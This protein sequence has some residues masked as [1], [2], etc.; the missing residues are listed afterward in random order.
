MSVD[1]EEVCGGG[2]IEL[3]LLDGSTASGDSYQYAHETFEIRTGSLKRYVSSGD[4][5]QILGLRLPI[6]CETFHDKASTLNRQD[7]LK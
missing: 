6:H 1:H 3:L 7:G 2:A 5:W 4:V